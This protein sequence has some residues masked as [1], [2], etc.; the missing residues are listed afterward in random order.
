MTAQ[1]DLEQMKWCHIR[2]LENNQ[3]VESENLNLRRAIVGKKIS[4]AALRSLRLY[5][6]IRN[7]F[8]C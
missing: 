8:D 4:P 7:E 6:A 1:K 2:S 5:L 3:I